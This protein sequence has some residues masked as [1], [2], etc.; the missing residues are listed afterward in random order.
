MTEKERPTPEQIA[1]LKRLSK[2]ARVDDW[3]EIVTS[4]EEAEARIRSLK[5]DARTE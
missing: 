5:E 4:K 2:E 1:E 3:S